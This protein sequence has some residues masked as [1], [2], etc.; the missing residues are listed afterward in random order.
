[1]K[2]TTFIHLF[3]N[4]TKNIL[5]DKTLLMMLVLPL[6]MTF[7][8]RLG[9][10][11]LNELLPSLANYYPL[12]LA[13]LATTSG[14]LGGYIIA[15]VMLEEKDEN[16]FPV[17]RVMP[18]SMLLFLTYRLLLAGFWAFCFAFITFLV[19]DIQ[20]Y[21]LLEKV[22][23]ALLCSQTAVVVLLFIV[24]FANNKIEGMT[25]IKGIN[26]FTVLPTLAFFID[27]SWKL[28]FGIFPF[29]WTYKTLQEPNFLWILIS[30][31]SHFI[32]LMTGYYFFTKKIE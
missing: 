17:I 11:A 12:A 23:Y 6:L 16:V 3:K 19:L 20:N 7:G 10:P 25:F 26:F 9:L 32:V 2:P 28:F 4:D 1:M 15:F 24:A 31:V 13:V 18:F 29:Y 5:R 30:I 27:S 22:V 8:L 14:L 21:S